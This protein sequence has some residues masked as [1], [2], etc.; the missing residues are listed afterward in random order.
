MCDQKLQDL[1]NHPAN[2]K[3]KELLKAWGVSPSPDTLHTLDLARTW[4]EKMPPESF[5]FD[6]ASLWELKEQAGIL[7]LDGDQVEVQKLLLSDLASV[8]EELADEEEP[9]EVILD[10]WM[11]SLAVDLARAGTPEA[12]G[13]ILVENLY[14]NLRE[15]Y[16]GF[17]G[18]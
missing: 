6:R 9:E 13:Q 11:N 3:A 2:Q 8:E 12:A 18:P 1:N 17:G 7:A 10:G 14:S 4:L 16:P 15:K 5:P